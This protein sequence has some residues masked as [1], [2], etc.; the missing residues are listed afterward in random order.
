LAILP[1]HYVVGEGRVEV[2]SDKI[3]SHLLQHLIMI[4]GSFGYPSDVEHP[5][6]RC[7]ADDHLA[8]YQM[9]N[10]HPDAHSEHPPEVSTR[11]RLPT[12][13][14]ARKKERKV[15]AFRPNHCAVLVHRSIGPADEEIVCLLSFRRQ[16]QNVVNTKLNVLRSPDCRQAYGA[17]FIR[18][19]QPHAML[20]KSRQMIAA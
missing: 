1:R 9:N 3:G 11:K 18:R 12:D 10:R 14:L 2:G 13:P 8:R 17:V 20:L 5:R 15:P 7:A 19:T 4:S 16:D 6:S